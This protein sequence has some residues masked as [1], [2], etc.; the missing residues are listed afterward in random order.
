MVVLLA[1]LELVHRLC[2]F[3]GTAVWAAAPLAV[4]LV[5]DMYL[6]APDI[7]LVALHI[8]VDRMQAERV[9]PGSSHRHTAA[10]E[11]YHTKAV[12]P[13][14]AR[15]IHIQL[16]VAKKRD[17]GRLLAVDHRWQHSHQLRTRM[18]VRHK[19]ASSLPQLPEPPQFAVPARYLHLALQD[20]VGRLYMAAAASPC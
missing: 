6:A 16:F 5:L 1:G 9:A 12:V 15:N 19:L 2:S 4:G 10:V 7:R 17:T 8:V 13:A 18:L 14:A 3:A 20:Q 11:A